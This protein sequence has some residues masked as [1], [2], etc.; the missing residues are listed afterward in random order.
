MDLK[1]IEKNY[2]KMSDDKLIRIA[3]IDASGLRPEVFGIIEK[4][5][6]KRN[7]SP[8]LL[9]GA[10]AQNRKH[11]MAEIEEY[12]KLLRDLPCPLCG[13]T[14]KKLNGTTLYTIKAYVFFTENSMNPVIACPDCLDKKN[15]DAI[16]STS[17]LGWWSI[18]SGLFKTPVYIYRNMQAKKENRIKSANKTLLSYVVGNIGEIEAYKGD[19]EKLMEVINLKKS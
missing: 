14:R 11:T 15:D 10:L 5:I 17:M 1:D 2:E 9:K 12:A 8:D 18:P 4:E 6:K 19:R 3:T 13:D 16:L 7:L